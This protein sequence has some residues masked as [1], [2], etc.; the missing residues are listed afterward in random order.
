MK[1][2]LVL[3]KDIFMVVGL[4]KEIGIDV[5]GITIVRIGQTTVLI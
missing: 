3:A 4:I 5:E 2:I 1:G